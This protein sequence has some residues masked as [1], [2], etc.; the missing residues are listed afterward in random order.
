M[1]GVSAHKKI[2]VT[3][4]RGNRVTRVFLPFYILMFI[5]KAI[6]KIARNRYIKISPGVLEDYMLILEDSCCSHRSC[7]GFPGA[8]L[9]HKNRPMTGAYFYIQVSPSRQ[10]ISHFRNLHL[11]IQYSFEPLWNSEGFLNGVYSYFLGYP[12]RLY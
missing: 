1:H 11:H 4:A 8:V 7:W 12:T 6:K 5:P 3:R 9:R 10:F 2:A